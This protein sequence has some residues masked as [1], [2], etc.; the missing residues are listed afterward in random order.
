MHVNFPVQY[1]LSWP[2]PFHLVL[3]LL[4][5]VLFAPWFFL[6]VVGVWSA[7]LLIY[8]LL[9]QIP[10]LFFQGVYP[11][12]HVHV[13]WNHHIWRMISSV[14]LQ[15]LKEYL[16]EPVIKDH[17]IA[18]DSYFCQDPKLPNGVGLPTVRDSNLQHVGQVFNA[19]TNG[20]E[21][22]HFTFFAETPMPKNCSRNTVPKWLID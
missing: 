21:E 7:T 2:L 11:W 1:L 4:S 9:L 22:S 16:W 13:V 10:M 12:T 14:S 17:H 3:H 5:L 6:A 15:L 18:H 20:P 19:R 8:D